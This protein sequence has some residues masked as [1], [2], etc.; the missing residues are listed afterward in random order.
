[1]CRG[2]RLNQAVELNDTNSD[3][4]DMTDSGPT[5][6]PNISDY[7]VAYSTIPGHVSFRNNNNGSILFLFIH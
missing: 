3:E 4:C 5:V 2:T 1:M 7:L 6:L